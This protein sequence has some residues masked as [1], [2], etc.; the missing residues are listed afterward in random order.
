MPD[1]RTNIVGYTSVTVKPNKYVALGLQFEKIEGNQAIS[2]SNLV[3]RTGLTADMGWGSGM[4]Q[5]WV[6]DTKKN[7]WAFYGYKLELPWDPE[8]TW[9][10]KKCTDRSGDG[11]MGTF[12]DLTDEDVLVP[13]D[14]FL[15]LHAD[16][17]ADISLSLSG[18]VKPFTA[19][20]S[21]TIAPNKYQ[22][23]AYPWPVELNIADLPNYMTNASAD[24]SWGSNMEQIWVM[25]PDPNANEWNFYGYWKEFPWAEESKMMKCTDRSGDGGM[26]TFVDLTAAD[27]IPA[28]QGFL[29]LHSDNGENLGINF[30]YPTEK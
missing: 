7:E 14:T 29:I 17:G 23:V 3:S 12:T 16:N 28:G 25:N 10:W 2:V 11:G 8:S 19:S 6:M 24:M 15:F 9:Q 21:Y 22:F 26:G 4:D 1:I 27:K 5:I 13:G 20:A 18:A 30:T